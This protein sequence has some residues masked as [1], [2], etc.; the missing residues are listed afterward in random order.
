M[1]YGI[2]SSRLILFFC[3]FNIF[4]MRLDL[5]LVDKKIYPTRAK[6]VA[7]IKAGLVTVNN[8]IAQ[9]PS[10]QI[11]PTDVLVGRPLPYVSGRGS[12]KLAQALDSFKINPTDFVCLDV[13][14]S[15]GGF[16]E[17]L[18]ARGARRVIAVDVGTGQLAPALKNDGRVCSM[19]NTDVRDLVPTESVDL[20]VV[21]VSF[22]SLAD[23]AGALSRWGATNIIALIKPQF[24]V[25]RSVSAAARGVIRAPQWHQYSI[26]RAKDACA[27]FGFECAGVI[28]SPILGGSGNA[29]FL[30]LFRRA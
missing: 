22:I 30:G 9:K 27:E 20:I 2:K 1:A 25:P 16:T 24:E 17:V 6:A 21:D 3:G 23:I 5:A 8:I 4:G 14:A 13:G 18:L 7:A 28:D 15:T 12:L 11:L 26:R 10:Q 19:E 29:E